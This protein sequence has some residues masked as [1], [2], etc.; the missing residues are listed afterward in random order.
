LRLIVTDVKRITVTRTL[1][2]PQRDRWDG[3]VEAARALASAGGYEA[4][5][6]HDVAAG[7]GLSRATLYRYFT[8]K[9]HLL[10]EL[11][12]RWIAELSER[13][14]ADPPPGETPAER[15]RA[16][17]DRVVDA[18]EAEPLLTEAVVR[19]ALSPEAGT[20]HD[21]LLVA[22][23]G[24][25]FDAV[26]GGEHE[27][28]RPEVGVVIGNVLFSGLIGFALH[29]RSAAELRELLHTTVSA[30]LRDRR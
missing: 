23:T 30:V 3:A 20:W 27:A 24:G 17:L 5:A 10:G 6:M 22:L 28:H 8:S 25:Y 9:D 13:F 12:A 26:L 2:P 11:S 18:A 14:A 21:S 16:V 15:L 7:A 29:G 1:R 19:A 4:V